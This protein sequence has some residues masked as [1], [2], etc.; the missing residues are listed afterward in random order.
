MC[1]NRSKIAGRSVVYYRT[2][3]F[4]NAKNFYDFQLKIF[5]HT[6]LDL[7]FMVKIALKYL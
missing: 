7:K 4:F 2:V 3:R 5:R 1:K 6:G